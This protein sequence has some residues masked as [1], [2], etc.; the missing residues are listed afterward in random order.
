MAGGSWS[1]LAVIGGFD[2]VLLDAPCSWLGI[3]RTNAHFVQVVL[4]I[5]PPPPVWI[6]DPCDTLH[7]ICLLF[8][9][10]GGMRVRDQEG[11]GL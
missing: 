8:Q 10:Q 7:K 1:Y 3:H 5:S 9:T 4:S 6:T 11:Q 2:Q